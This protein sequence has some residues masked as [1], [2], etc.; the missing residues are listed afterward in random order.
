MYYNFEIAV[1]HLE[2]YDQLL[3]VV[4]RA[5]SNGKSMGM[6]A[7]YVLL[8]GHDDAAYQTAF[9]RIKSVLG[10]IQCKVIYADFEL[11]LGNNARA[12]LKVKVVLKDC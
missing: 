10:S 4:Y 2:N 7:A 8:K 9:T 1:S 3:V 11:S 6:P 12:I 5:K